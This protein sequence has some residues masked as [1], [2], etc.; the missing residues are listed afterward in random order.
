MNT[1]IQPRMEGYLDGIEEGEKRMKS[2][3]LKLIE[4]EVCY[5]QLNNK[6]PLLDKKSLIYKIKNL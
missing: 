2:E 3:I 5:Y 1:R 6:E 4:C